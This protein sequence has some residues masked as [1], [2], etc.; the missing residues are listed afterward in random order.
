MQIFN[1]ECE[2]LFHFINKRV[3]EQWQQL[4]CSGS[5][6]APK[7][8]ILIALWFQLVELSDSFGLV[9]TEALI[10]NW[11]QFYR[12]AWWK[13]EDNKVHFENTGAEHTETL[14]GI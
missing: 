10:P 4:Y 11:V 2:I 6:I 3:C 5:I 13:K 7:A 12:S 8:H 9:Y 1:G 14:T